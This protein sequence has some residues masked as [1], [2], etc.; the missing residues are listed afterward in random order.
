MAA[1]VIDV[2]N[3]NN[4]GKKIRRA[5]TDNILLRKELNSVNELG[6]VPQHL[7]E[8]YQCVHSQA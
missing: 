7:S 2:Q 1:V 4:N 3:E 5:G 6:S 8:T